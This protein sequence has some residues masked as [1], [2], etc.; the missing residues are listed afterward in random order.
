[1]IT[2]L[3]MEPFISRRE[4]EKCLNVYFISYL[5][6]YTFNCLNHEKEAQ[7]MKIDWLISY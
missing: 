2:E 1:M 5:E 6:I 3:V 7:M 4:K